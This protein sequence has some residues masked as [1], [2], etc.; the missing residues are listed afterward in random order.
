ML[1]NKDPLFTLFKALIILFSEAML[2]KITQLNSNQNK[3]M[4]PFYSNFIQTVLN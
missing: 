3:M 4:M 2:S 1:E